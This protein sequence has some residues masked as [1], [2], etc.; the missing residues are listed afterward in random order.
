MA[1][2]VF[3]AEFSERSNNQGVNPN[4][5]ELGIREAALCLDAADVRA[6]KDQIGARFRERLAHQ[7]CQLF[8]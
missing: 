7:I 5:V 4:Q 1:P 8:A 3:T 2:L 6:F